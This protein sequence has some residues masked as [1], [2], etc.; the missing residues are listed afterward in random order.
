M[1]AFNTEAT[2]TCDT[3]YTLTNGSD[4][5]VCG[6]DDSN[7]TGAWSGTAPGCSG[8]SIDLMNDLSI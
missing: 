4:V 8:N 1:L 2:H 6:G 3:F 5:R 7:T